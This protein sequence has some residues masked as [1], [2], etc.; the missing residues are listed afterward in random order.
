VSCNCKKA[1][2]VAKIETTGV[3]LS[4]FICRMPNVLQDRSRSNT[5]R[6]YMSTLLKA[7]QCWPMILI[8]NLN[9]CNTAVSISTCCI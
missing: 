8:T 6:M 1:E 5:M 7:M 4:Y 9:A 2:H 3:T